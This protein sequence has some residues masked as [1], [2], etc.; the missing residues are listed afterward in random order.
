MGEIPTGNSNSF[1]TSR[2]PISTAACMEEEGSSTEV[3][4]DLQTLRKGSCWITHLS[5]CISYGV[6]GCWIDCHSKC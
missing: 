5:N 1:V 4:R 3:K 6:E 2:T